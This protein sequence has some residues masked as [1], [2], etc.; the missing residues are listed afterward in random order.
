MHAVVFWICFIAAVIYFWNRKKNK[1]EQTPFTNKLSY[2]HQSVESPSLNAEPEKARSQDEFLRPEARGKKASVIVEPSG[3]RAVSRAGGF[4]TKLLIVVGIAIAGGVVAMLVVLSKATGDDAGDHSSPAL[5][6]GSLVWA[7]LER[8]TSLYQACANADSIE[9]KRRLAAKECS[10]ILSDGNAYRLIN[11]SFPADLDFSKSENI[12]LV[13]SNELID[14][15]NSRFWGRYLLEELPRSR[16]AAEV[17]M[18]P[19]P[20]PADTG[21]QSPRKETLDCMYRSKSL[22]ASDGRTEYMYC[23]R[24][25]P[26]GTAME[27]PSTGTPEQTAAWLDARPQGQRGVCSGLYSVEGARVSFKCAY[28]SG[29]VVEHDGNVESDVMVLSTH[30]SGNDHSEVRRYT[31]YVRQDN[32]ERTNQKVEQDGSMRDPSQQ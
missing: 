16:V 3:S 28:P 18:M 6:I 1:R 26:D 25:F 4:I 23:I 2:T 13:D 7:K 19:S 9:V 12:A 21:M 31:L 30:S 10:A 14:Y 8:A 27:T 15:L 5:P 17:P 24:F 20:D 32:S 11:W 22:I 29:N